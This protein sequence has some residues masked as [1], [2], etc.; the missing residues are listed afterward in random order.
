[1]ISVIMITSAC[2]SFTIAKLLKHVKA[3]QSVL[4]IKTV[5]VVLTLPMIYLAFYLKELS[6]IYLVVCFVIIFG[7]SD[8]C[9]N[10][11][12]SVY[13]SENFPGQLEAFNIFKQN[14]NFFCSLV[15]VIYISINESSFMWLNA[16]TH[17]VLAICVVT[18]FKG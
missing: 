2:T 8:I 7:S 4:L 14:Q 18:F 6:S 3:E 1:M 10:Q 5:S 11:L 12:N 17:I 16:I 9:F 13:L 15:A